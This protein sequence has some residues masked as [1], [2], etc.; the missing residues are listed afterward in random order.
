[1]ILTTAMDSDPPQV[2]S[3]AQTGVF[4]A[5]EWSAIRHVQN[6]DPVQAAQALR[7]LC[8]RYRLPMVNWFRSHG[9]TLEDAEDLTHQFLV[10][11]LVEEHLVQFDRRPGVSFR[12]WLA[13]CLRRLLYDFWRKRGR[14]ERLAEFSGWAEASDATEADAALDRELARRIHDQVLVE[15]RGRWD[16]SGRRPVLDALLPLIF[17][18]PVPDGGYREPAQACGLTESQAKGRLFTIRAEYSELFCRQVRVLCLPGD[19]AAED[20]YLK[21]LA[22]DAAER[23]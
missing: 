12:S 23:D 4:P 11:R 9:L 18:H 2:A 8:E 22:M 10:R 16:R 1:M 6:Q 17:A 21:S 5:T 14:S 7:E 19:L 3:S 20:S 15:M 13:Q